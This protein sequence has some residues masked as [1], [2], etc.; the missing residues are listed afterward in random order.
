MDHAGN[1]HLLSATQEFGGINTSNI[2]AI[3]QLEPF[4]KT[5]T[6]RASIRRAVGGW[7]AAKRQAWFC[8]PLLGSTDNGLR[9]MLGY[10]PIAD[11]QQGEI[12]RLFMSRR[13]ICVSIWMRP[14]VNNIPRPTVG[15]ASGFIWRLDDDSRNKDGVAYS[16]DFETANTDLSFIDESLA[17]K[18]KAGQFL[19]L[20]SE[21]RGDWDLTINVFWDDILTDVI[22][23]T[24]GGG[25]A[26]IG[27][28]ILDTDILG[29]DVVHSKRKRMEGSGRRIK[30][31]GHNGGLDQDITLADFHISFNVM[32]E[33]IKEQ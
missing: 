33:R 9:I 25:G 21:P 22:Q 10:S 19:E 29:S 16:I 31:S 17:T 2:S 30:I 20:A 13:D 7:Y 11:Q 26:A 23:F 12:P 5:D 27:G 15:D 28:F 8:V 4:M 18:M 32:D 24:M 14:D 1:I 3:A 6:N